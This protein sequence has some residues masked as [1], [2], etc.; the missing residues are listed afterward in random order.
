MDLLNLY[1]LL[2]HFEEGIF[3][4]YYIVDMKDPLVKF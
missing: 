2:H 3:A 1:Q 4:I